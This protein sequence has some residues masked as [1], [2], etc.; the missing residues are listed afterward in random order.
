MEMERLMAEVFTRTA[1]PDVPCKAEATI[2]RSW[3]KADP[4]WRDGRLIPVEDAAA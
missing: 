1:T 4:V 3:T 2:M